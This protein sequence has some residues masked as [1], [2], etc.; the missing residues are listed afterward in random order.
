MSHANNSGLDAFRLEVREFLDRALTPELRLAGTMQTGV[1]SEPPIG[2]KWHKA[3]YEQGWITPTWPIEYGGTGWTVQQNYVFQQ[4]IARFNAPTLSAAGLQMCGPILIHYGTPEQRARFLPR[5]RSGEDYW[6]Q[7]YSEPG[8]GS[9]LASLACRATRDGDEYV[10]DGSKL[11]TTHAHHADWIFMLV[12]TSTE[13]RRQQGI[14][15]LLVDMR[16]LGIKVDPIISMSGD[17]DVNQVFFDEVRVP[18]ANRIGE[19]GEGWSIAK[20]LLEFE[21]GIIWVPRI[22]RLL[23]SARRLAKIYGIWT[24]PEFER[25]FVDLSIS[26]DVLEAAEL[27]MLGSG[28]AMDAST[29]SLLKLAGAELLQKASDLSVYASGLRSAYTYGSASEDQ[30]VRDGAMVMARYLNLRAG[31]IYGGSSEVQRNILA[32]VNLGL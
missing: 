6:C 15:F 32:K 22:R 5:L 26:A 12:R 10:I 14:T 16:S 7:G 4:E 2:R 28:R 23:A 18:V 20:R 9:D 24:Q 3:L 21:R 11:W 17:H 30:E 8:A 13:A 31:T 27:R 1:F 29:S 19:E 25:R